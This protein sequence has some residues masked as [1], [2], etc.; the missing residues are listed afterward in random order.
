MP[1]IVAERRGRVPVELPS[2][3]L[4]TPLSLAVCVAIA[5]INGGAVFMAY[6]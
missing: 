4:S 5:S 1:A 3:V 6:R 2:Q